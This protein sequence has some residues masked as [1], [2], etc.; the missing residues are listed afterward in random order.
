VARITPIARP[1]SDDSGPAGEATAPTFKYGHGPLI[2]QPEVVAIFWGSAWATLEHQPLVAQLNAFFDYILR[3][4]FID[5]I[6]ADYSVYAANYTFVG[7]TGVAGDKIIAYGRRAA[8]VVVTDPEPG[9]VQRGVR[10]VTDDDVRAFLGAKI[11][12]VLPRTTPN[13]AFFVFLPP[14]VSSTYKEKNRDGT[15][16]TFTSCGTRNGYCGYHQHIDGPPAAHYAVV[17]FADCA[18]CTVGPTV[19]DSLTAWAAHELCEILTDPVLGKGWV[20]GDLVGF[21]AADYCEQ[22]GMGT[23]GGYTVSQVWSPSTGT[24]GACVVSGKRVRHPVITV[25]LSSVQLDVPVNV[26]IG[27]TDALTGAPTNGDVQINKQRAGT[28]NRSFIH[29]FEPRTVRGPHGV[30]QPANPEVRVVATG[31]LTTLVD[32][33][34]PPLDA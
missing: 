13:T 17:P 22:A 21:E 2:T 8:T 14:G 5:I 27:A 34:F 32:C 12:N 4:E 7:T 26:L 11:G 20:A 30:L 19:F 23:L 33:G 31:H 28:T 3:S 16:A 6:S 15:W 9:T 10:H 24:T 1:V 18:A 29:T 25:N